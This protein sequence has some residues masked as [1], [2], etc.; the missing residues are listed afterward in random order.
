M[1]VTHCNEWSPSLWNK[2]RY[3]TMWLHHILVKPKVKRPK[4]RSGDADMS[5]SGRVDCVWI[6]CVCVCVCVF[7]IWRIW[8]M[9]FIWCFVVSPESYPAGRFVQT[10]T[11]A[12]LCG[13]VWASVYTSTYIYQGIHT[14]GSAAHLYLSIDFE[15]NFWSM[16]RTSCSPLLSIFLSLSLL[17]GQWSSAA[18]NKQTQTESLLD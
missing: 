10:H 15:L 11:E 8:L 13:C 1:L 16:R 12:Y 17:S 9:F 3:W 14:P 5:T 4:T 2:L 6:V 7:G 18:A